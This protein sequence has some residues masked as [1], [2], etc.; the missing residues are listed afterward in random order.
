M[1]EEAWHEAQSPI[2][3]SVSSVSSCSS[4]NGDVLAGACGTRECKS[5]K[6]R[7]SAGA[8]ELLLAGV[9][10]GLAERNAEDGVE[11]REHPINSASA[12]ITSGA[13]PD[14]TGGPAPPPPPHRS[15]FCKP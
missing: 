9:A 6:A 11:R 13:S 15:L 7:R 5:S 14:G 3:A 4:S 10:R 2:P 1:A 8:L 12:A